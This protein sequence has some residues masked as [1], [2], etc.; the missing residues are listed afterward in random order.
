MIKQRSVYLDTVKGIAILLML[1]GHVIQY[2]AT[3]DFDFYENDVFRLI[4]SFHMPL[5]MLVSGYLF[6]C[7]YKKSSLRALFAKRV[8]SLVHP[9]IMCSIFNYFFYVACFEFVNGKGISILFNG[10]WIN[11]LD[12]LWFLWSILAAVVA[13][14]FVYEIVSKNTVRFFCLIF[15]SVIV[16]LFPG[17]QYNLYMYPYFVLGFLFAQYEERL[18]VALFRVRYISI[19]LF[20]IL[21]TFYR[22]EHYIYTSSISFMGIFSLSEQIWIDL[23]RWLIGFVGSAF[24][25][26]VTEIVLKKILCKRNLIGMLGQK[27][28]E[29]YCL[30][31]PF[32]S[33]WLEKGSLWFF[34]TVWGYNPIARHTLI[35]NYVFTPVITLLYVISIYMLVKMLE[36]FKVSKLLFGK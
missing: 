22:K 4:Y 24:V 33:Y 6:G 10:Q 21:F 30:S 34:A 1:W 9:L 23:F 31:I 14:C 32:V 7:S 19:V 26:T 11:H 13:I 36:K 25:L 17:A 20:P 16:L 29:I 27:S 15:A 12:S 2:C 8:Q 18:P 5:F 3:G 28:L 35:Y